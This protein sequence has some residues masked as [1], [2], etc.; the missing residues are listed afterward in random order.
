MT[1]C[2]A[3]VVIRTCHHLPRHIDSV[4]IVQRPVWI[5]WLI[6]MCPARHLLRRQIEPSHPIWIHPYSCPCSLC[7]LYHKNMVPVQSHK[8]LT[9]LSSPLVW[10]RVF[11]WHVETF[12]SARG[13]THKNINIATCTNTCHL[14]GLS[15]RQSWLETDEN[16]T[17]PIFL[18]TLSDGVAWCFRG[19]YT[20]RKS[21][22]FVA[23]NMS[24]ATYRT[25]Y[26][27][28]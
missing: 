8:L 19:W 22:D 11:I 18:T 21:A 28:L 20:F 5:L 7:S 12:I 6:N 16:W 10:G 27:R 14:I 4:A 9:F 2:T 3:A 24:Y 23:S 26:H 1:L 25:V 17:R 15:I 13:H